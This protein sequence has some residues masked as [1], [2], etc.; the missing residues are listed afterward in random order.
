MLGLYGVLAYAVSLR[1]RELGIRMALGMAAR[2]GARLVI[3][4]GVR[5]AVTGVAI[6]AAGSMALS[7]A[8]ATVLHDVSALHAPTYAGMA[9]VLVL[10]SLAASWLPARRAMTVDPTVALRQE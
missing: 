1:T 4:D 6:G 2:D 8:I 5:L 9:A 7:R 3:V 10:T